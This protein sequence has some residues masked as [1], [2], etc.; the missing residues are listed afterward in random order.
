[1]PHRGDIFAPG[2][3]YH[4]YNRG[5]NKA[6]IFTGA[7]NCR[8]LLGKVKRLLKEIPATV[9]AYCLMPNHY[10]F[11]M[12]Q[13]RKHRYPNSSAGCSRAIP[14]PITASKSEQVLC[15]PGDFD[16][17]TLARKNI[18]YICVAT[19]I[20]TLLRL[21]WWLDPRI[22]PL[23]TTWNGSADARGRWLIVP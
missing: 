1:M 4:L 17:F 9:I 11:V 14:R 10:H 7:D 16:A 20:S 21:A 3:A 15:L 22:G 19:F 5:L 6:D 23:A 8:F 13:E 12:R 2:N 18:C